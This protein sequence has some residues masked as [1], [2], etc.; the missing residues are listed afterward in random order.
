MAAMQQGAGVDT[1]G[2]YGG[3]GGGGSLADRITR[4]IS[5]YQ[6]RMA[7]YQASGAPQQQMPGLFGVGQEMTY[8]PRPEPSAEVQRYLSWASRVPPGS[9]TSPQAYQAFVEGLVPTALPV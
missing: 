6:Q 8:G 1:S 4:G 7:E 9:D 5:S 2:G 3:S